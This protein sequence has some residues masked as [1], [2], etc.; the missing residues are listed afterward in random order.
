MQTES[1][2]PHG[3]MEAEGSYNRNARIPAGGVA[4]A[5]PLLVEAVERIAVGPLLMGAGFDLTGSYRTP[6]A[7]LFISTLLATALI[8]QLGPYRYHARRPEENASVLQVQVGEQPCGSVAFNSGR[9]IAIRSK[10]Q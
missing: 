4:L 7:A 9:H 3:V 6:L 5:L 1:K 10:Q 2:L 8:A